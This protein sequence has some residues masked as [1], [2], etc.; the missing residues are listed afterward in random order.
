MPKRAI[1]D[2]VAEAD[3]K[4]IKL[5]KKFLD[6]AGELFKYILPYKTKFFF[7]LITMGVSSLLGLIFPYVTGELLDSALSGKHEGWLGS[8]DNLTIL[9]L[10][11][12]L[13]QAFF[14][15]FQSVLFVE[16]S[17]RSLADIRRETYA[18]L[19]RL[20]MA[21][22]AH[23]RVGELTSRISADLTQIQ[24]T[25]AISL[26]QLLRQLTIMIGGLILIGTMS[27]KLTLIML[28]VFPL[29][30][31]VSVIIGRKIRTMSREAQDRL[32]D[33]NIVV[34]ETL[35][36][37]MNVKAFANEGYEIRRYNTGLQKYISTILRVAK[38]RGAFISFLIF[39]LFSSIVIVLWSGARFVQQ[40][41]MSIGDLT[42]FLL[43]TTFIGAAMGSFADLYSQLQKAIGATERIREILREKTEPV[44]LE[45]SSREALRSFKI[46]GAV[47]FK[48]VS[49]RY[50]SR[51]DVPVLKNISFEVNAGERV[52][53]V[54]PSGAGKSTLVSLLQRFYEPNAGEIIVDGKN[55]LDYPL[56]ALRNQMAIVPQD[57]ILFGG[58]IR[59]NIAYGKPGASDEEILDAAKKAHADEFISRFPD[60]YNTFVGERGVKL[61]GGQR[62]R[63]AIA[64]AIL[65]NPSILLL[66]EA[67]SSLDSESERL[68][69]AALENLMKGR[70]SFIIAHRLS[71]VRDVEKIVVLKDG[72]VHEIGTHHELLAKEDGL[73]KMLSAIQFDLE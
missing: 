6:E 48:N 13:L 41:E 63:I 73:Y 47:A 4:R 45:H 54:G 36:G 62:Q 69:Q 5:N 33:A 3:V 50:P 1:T 28:S 8:I 11:S 42:S 61:S 51:N 72:E 15:F 20:P 14:S 67:T 25:L 16:V 32:A 26:S 12:L 27:W 46:S 39:G 21:F 58:S 23:R 7:A 55:I 59:E 35:Q 34:E 18:Q 43:Y 64:R 24:D 31:L 17:E 37:V 65:S 22:F 29:M 71:T 70:T 52:A 57:I 9:L 38:Y 66:D 60:G 10:L 2:E 19:V 68:V 44:S 30:A 40:G 49:F 53:L 56:T